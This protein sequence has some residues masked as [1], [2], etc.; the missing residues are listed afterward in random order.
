MS[1]L[2][3]THEL[4]S[5]DFTLVCLPG[6]GGR[7]WDIIYKGHSL[8]FQNPDLLGTTPDLSNLQALPTKS[9]QFSIPLWGG[10]KTWIAPDSLW[11]EQA[12]YPELDSGSYDVTSNNP[13]QITMRSKVCPL[14]GLQ[15]EREI[16]LRTP[17]TW[18]INHKI[19]NRGPSPRTAGIWSVMMLDRPARI[20]AVS[21]G[22]EA[23]FEVVFGDPEECVSSNG[24]FLLHHCNKPIE[25]KTG[26]DTSSS[27]VIIRLGSELSGAYLAC[28][29][30]PRESKDKFA[31]GH[32]FEV[33]NSKDYDYC[34]AEWHSPEQSLPVGSCTEF[35]Q[36][37]CIWSGN[38][39]PA[40]IDLLR[41]EQELLACMS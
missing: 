39:L 22:S 35:R 2:W 31:H 15:V 37:F 33:F 26:A 30:P 12:P 29:I 11:H 4:T 10:E 23:N 38:D 27:K 40:D 16:A 14:S 3:T 7:L 21:D 17:S 1:D 8:L 25:F 13:E 28:S 6:I 20:A 5:D 19:I 41:S 36:E 18:T 32:N 9:P 34:E 24:R